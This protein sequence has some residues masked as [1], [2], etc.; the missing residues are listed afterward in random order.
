MKTTDELE[1]EIEDLWKSGEI[2][3][4]QFRQMMAILERAKLK[5]KTDNEVS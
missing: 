1:K 2:N 3:V 5:E 4:G